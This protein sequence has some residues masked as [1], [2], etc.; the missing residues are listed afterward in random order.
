M[1]ICLAYIQLA[2][3]QFALQTFYTMSSGFVPEGLSDLEEATVAS[4][5][6][7]SWAKAEEALKVARWQQEE[8]ES[9][10]RG[11]E[12]KSLY[13]ILQANKGKPR[14]RFWLPK[15]EVQELTQR[16]RF[17]VFTLLMKNSTQTG[18]V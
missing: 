15:G 7:D 14:Y 5:Q 16:R 10:A 17:D 9:L 6:E 3:H 4:T 1:A 11:S 13:E 18:R 2:I 12:G 8:D